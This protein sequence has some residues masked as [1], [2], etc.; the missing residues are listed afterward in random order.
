[1][2]DTLQRN[3]A[4]SRQAASQGSLPTFTEG[5][6]ILVARSD[7]TAG[8]TLALRCRGPHR[9]LKALNDYT[10]QVEDLRHRA[11]EDI[12]GSRLKFYS[13][14]ALDKTAIMSHVLSSKTGMPVAR[15]LALVQDAEGLKIRIRWKVSPASEYTLEPILR[16]K[17][18]VPQILECLL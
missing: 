10:F 8:E 3:R 17:H 9:V 15:P 4:R 5:N 16:V 14:A 11:V 7:F 13:D 2:Q 18:D 6:F 12:H 1:M